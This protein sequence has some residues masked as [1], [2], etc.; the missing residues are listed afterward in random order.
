MR[1]A[2]VLLLLLPLAGCVGSE[3]AAGPAPLHTGVDAAG[4]EAG[5]F[6]AFE[7]AGGRLELGVAGGGRLDVELYDGS[8]RRVAGVRLDGAASAPVTVTVDAG[9][10]VLH[11]R[12]LDGTLDLHSH[13]RPVQRF[14]PLP[15]HLER[16]VLVQ[17]DDD[18][19][20]PLPGF[21]SGERVD[22]SAVLDLPRAPTGMRVLLNGR[23]DDLSVEARTPLGLVYEAVGGF[24]GTTFA[25]GSQLRPLPGEYHPGASQQGPLQVQVAAAALG[26]D[27]VLEVHSYSRASE[28]AARPAAAAG[29]LAFEY[30][31]LPAG[32][33][34]FQ[35]H[36]EAAHVGFASEG[37]A[38]V[39]LFGPNDARLGTYAVNGTVRIPVEAGGDHV[40]VLLEG[41]ASVGA[42]RAPADFQLAP[43]DRV[44]Q[45]V[46][47]E[48]TDASGRYRQQAANVAPAGVAYLVEPLARGFAFD[49]REG[50]ALL[51][52]HE[53]GTARV[54]QGGESLGFWGPSLQDQPVAHGARL[55]PAG[56]QVHF[57][58][59]G[60][61]SC[62]DTG[63]RVLSYQ[64]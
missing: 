19:V 53:A 20:L 15:V 2:L 26:G 4:V 58:G 39:A 1:R 23:A 16:H 30:G 38:V 54:E 35:V 40:A 49:P 51:Q 57:D 24:G 45:S 9:T 42:E 59:F 28:I 29:D 11:V 8:D 5:G 17:R 36:P 31:N 12:D 46:F 41:E 21:P 63:V 64:R 34:A 27:L 13:D 44:N 60:D 55:A 48:W 50:D 18:A 6:Y 3:E 62:Q 43:L 7:H 10:P 61:G 22:A 25:Q 33:A 47:P 56:F 37:G 14:W 32:P 52:C